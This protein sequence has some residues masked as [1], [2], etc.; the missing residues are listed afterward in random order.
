[1]G[2][3]YVLLHH[4]PGAITPVTDAPP[5]TEVMAAA[6]RR[7]CT[8]SLKR[9]EEPPRWHHGESVPW[10]AVT[11]LLRAGREDDAVALGRLLR[12]TERVANGRMVGFW[13]IRYENGEEPR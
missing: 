8:S 9:A 13:E 3:G 2:A 12:W 7:H 5:V 4:T 6:L 10:A 11:D 1:M